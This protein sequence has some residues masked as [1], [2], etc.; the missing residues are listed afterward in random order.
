MTTAAPIVLL[1]LGALAALVI[2]M[3]VLRTLPRGAV[4]AW[5]MVLFFVPVWVGVSAGFFWYGITAL[6]VVLS[7]CILPTAGWPPSSS[8][9]A[10]CTCSTA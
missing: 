6:T 8:C 9:W 3:I 2:A 10:S 7:D 1:A 4:V 5:A